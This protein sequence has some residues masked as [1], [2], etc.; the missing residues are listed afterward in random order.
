MAENT[1]GSRSEGNVEDINDSAVFDANGNAETLPAAVIDTS[2]FA[3][4]LLATSDEQGYEQAK[5]EITRIVTN[6]GMIFVP[7]IF[8][9]EIGNVLL[10]AAKKR[11]DG[12]D[13][14]I[15]V[16]DANDILYD[17]KQLPIVT[18]SEN[19]LDIMMRISE[20][21]RAKN[22]SFY[23]ATYLELA[24]RLALPLL[25]FDEKLKEID[26]GMKND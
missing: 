8:W 11:R 14:R 17:L 15:S 1:S 12:S 6:G 21:A 19:D 26:S 24:K 2:F 3:A 5:K 10:N 9:Y 20:L 25:T 7:H 13:A 23:D 4:F 16:T 22:I 18:N